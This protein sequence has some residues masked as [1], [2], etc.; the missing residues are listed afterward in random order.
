MEEQVINSLRAAEVVEYSYT[1]ESDRC[2][3]CEQLKPSFL[4]VLEKD[5]VQDNFTFCIACIDKV[6]T[7]PITSACKMALMRSNSEERYR[8]ERKNIA[9]DI[10]EEI[11]ALY[12]DLYRSINLFLDGNLTMSNGEEHPILIDLFNKTVK[13]NR[14]PSE[15]QVELFNKITGDITMA[16]NQG[17][18]YM[19]KFQGHE[20]DTLIH[21]INVNPVPAR[22]KDS[23]E[24]MIKQ[25]KEKGSLS[26]KQYNFLKG[27][28]N[29][30]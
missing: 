4:F 27:I 15:K 13:R 28:R 12:P 26:Y 11:D 8:M 22:F 23:V 5:G 10:T 16:K 21:A 9:V 1:K 30:Q 7:K 29:A 6:F 2:L 20:V 18:E 25:F 17:K 14:I 24:S 3:T 19:D